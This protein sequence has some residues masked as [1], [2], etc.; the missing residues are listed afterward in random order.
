MDN[1][2]FTT[3]LG[4][5]ILHYRSIA[6][7]SQDM[8]AKKSGVSKTYICMLENGTRKATFKVIVKLAKALE[9]DW[10]KLAISPVIEKIDNMKDISDEK[11]QELKS[12]VFGI[13]RI[14]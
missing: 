11:K 6:G 3:L 14:F 9:V 8:L 7:L 1:K 4:L 10:N 5:K 12:I 2:E 13:E